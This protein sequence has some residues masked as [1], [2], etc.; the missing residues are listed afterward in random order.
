MRI[1]A[2]NKKKYLELFRKINLSTYPFFSIIFCT[3]IACWFCVKKQE[4]WGSGREIFRPGPH[5]SPL[6]PGGWPR[7]RMMVQPWAGKCGAFGNCP[8]QE[9]APGRAYTKDFKE[10]KNSKLQLKNF[11]K[12][13][14][15]FIKSNNCNYEVS[16]LFSRIS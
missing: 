7:T 15:L 1:T 16:I 8:E 2:S 6:K 4:A 13:I 5:P 12:T 11:N 3:K 10:M 14:T 9:R